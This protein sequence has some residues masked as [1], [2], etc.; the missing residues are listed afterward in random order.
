MTE[1][2]L[3]GGGR[4]AG[5]VERMFEAFSRQLH[6]VE[7]RIAAGGAEIIK[8]HKTLGDL[9]KTMETLLSLD[10]KVAG[11]GEEGA[12]DLARIRTEVMERLSR[13]TPLRRKS[14]A[15]EKAPE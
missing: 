8:E 7:K 9:A 4:R 15:A 12:V 11:D 13:L 14:G 5:L 2:A 1:L 10:R 3:G 6:E